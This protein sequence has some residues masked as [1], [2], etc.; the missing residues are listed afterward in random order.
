MPA[1]TLPRR[2]ETY[3]PS[4]SELGPTEEI[5]NRLRH[6]IQTPISRIFEPWLPTEFVGQGVIGA[7]PAVEITESPKEF[8]VTAELPGMTA[9]DLH[10]EFENGVLTIRGEKQEEH[11]KEGNGD[12]RYLLWERSYGEFQRSFILPA[13]VDSEKVTAEFENGVLTVLLPKSDKAKENGHKITI[14]Q[15]K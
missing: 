6:I 1:M 8:T 7:Y 4:R 3:L 2:A 11:R 14:A 10:A 5:R 9:K 15:K 13:D 12:R